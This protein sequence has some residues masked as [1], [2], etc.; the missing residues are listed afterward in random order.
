MVGGGALVIIDYWRGKVQNFGIEFG[1]LREIA[2]V[3]GLY[4]G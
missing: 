2:V 4:H 1:Q 3:L